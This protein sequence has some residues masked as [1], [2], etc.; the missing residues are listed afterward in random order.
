MLW[1]N[2]DMTTRRTLLEKGL[3]LH[4]YLEVLLH[5]SAAVR[6]LAKDTLQ[7]VNTKMLTINSYGAADLP[8]DF[9][10][11]VAVSFPGA[12]LSH[13][14]KRDDLNPLRYVNPTTG[15][16]EPWTT[17]ETDPQTGLFPGAPVGCFWY[18]NVND[19]GEP[20]GR[21][22]GASGG[23]RYG[24]QI[25]R[26]RRQ[27]QFTGN[28]TSED[29]NQVA[30]MY[31]SNGQHVDNASQI[32]WRAFSA[33]QSYGDW[34]MSVRADMKDSPEASTFIWQKRNLRAEMNDLTCTDIINIFRNSYT[35]AYKT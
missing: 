3:P 11:E 17:S 2:L 26:E 7:I 15:A 33:I 14:P 27:I 30:F 8:G 34:K 10:D 24:Y 28:F 5:Q 18:W 31:V 29:T 35:A 4:F 9:V 12:Q 13:I 16:F 22:F 19:F 32:D 23:V 21:Y 20:T 1:A 6:E 25:F